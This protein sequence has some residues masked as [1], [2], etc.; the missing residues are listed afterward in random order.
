MEAK[1]F[2][3]R[4]WGRSSASLRQRLALSQEETK[5]SSCIFPEMFWLAVEDTLQVG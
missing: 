3:H 4:G 5:H 1:G 2:G